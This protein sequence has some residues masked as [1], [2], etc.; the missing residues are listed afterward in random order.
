MRRT[1]KIGIAAAPET[2]DIPEQENTKC[3][4]LATLN[5]SSP[6]NGTFSGFGCKN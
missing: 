3:E 1:G 4:T 2:P 5:P 6:S